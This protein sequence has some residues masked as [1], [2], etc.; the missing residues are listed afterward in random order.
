[1]I[2]KAIVSDKDG[3]SQAIEI[4]ELDTKQ[5]RQLRICSPFADD[6]QIRLKGGQLQVRYFTGSGTP[7]L[8]DVGKQTLKGKL[9]NHD[10]GNQEDEIPF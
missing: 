1:M 6:I 2:A 10:V 8:K 3:D 5:G 7:I 9:V 4:V